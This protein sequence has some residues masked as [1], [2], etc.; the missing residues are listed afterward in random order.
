[1]SDPTP[2]LTPVTRARHV[3]EL[4]FMQQAVND[5]GYETELVEP[6][7]A[8]ELPRLLVDLGIDDEERAR[9]AHIRIIPLEDDPDVGASATRFVEITVPLPIEVP[10]DRVGDV[11]QAVT[12]VNEHIAVGLFGLHST[13]SLYYRYV[14]ATA[15]EDMVPGE[16]FAEVMSFVDFHQDHFTDYLEGICVDEIDLVVLDRV[17]REST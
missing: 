1:V 10:D 2:A 8:G 14:L 11:R 15:F 17:I 16:M 12:I 9:V 7:D 6:D 4:G 5:A 13:G 3:A